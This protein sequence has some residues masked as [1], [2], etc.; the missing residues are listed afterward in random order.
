LTADNRLETRVADAVLPAGAL[1]PPRSLDTDL[2]T[3]LHRVPGAFYNDL[4]A[5]SD[6]QLG[7]D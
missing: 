7:S 2:F 4:D 1:E 3:V 6:H 5:V